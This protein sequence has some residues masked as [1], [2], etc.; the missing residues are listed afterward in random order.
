M[1]GKEEK[2]RSN[3]NGRIQK[4]PTQNHKKRTT[5]IFWAYNQ[6]WWTRKANIEW[7]DLWYQKQRKTTYN[8]HR[9]SE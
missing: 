7:R 1:G 4:I 9:Q 6:S 5:S 2:L 3:G 8:I